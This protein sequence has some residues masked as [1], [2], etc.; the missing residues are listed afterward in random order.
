VQVYRQQLWV[1]WSSPD[2][3]GA[4]RLRLAPLT[5]GALGEP[6]V[7]QDAPSDSL[8]DLSL[9]VFADELLVMFTDEGWAQRRRGYAPLGV[10]Q[11]NGASFH[12]LRKLAD[13]GR[14]TDA[15]GVQLGSSFYLFHSTDVPWVSY[16]GRFR[17]LRLTALLPDTPGGETITYLDDMKHN[18]SCSATVFENSVYVA[19]EKLEQEPSAS[20]PPPHSYGTFLSRIDLGPAPPARPR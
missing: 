13:L 5:D 15:A 1:M 11:F 16:G 7:W 12:W 17:D 10:V 14:N 18:L 8:R 19:H 3:Q 2:E 20:T 4:P 6:H 9:G